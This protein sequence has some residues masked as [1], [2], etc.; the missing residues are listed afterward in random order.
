MVKMTILRIMK[1]ATTQRKT[2]YC[3][4]IE[5]A[6][7]TLGHATNGQL[8]TK[9]RKSYPELSATT[10]HRASSRLAS[11]G[12]ISV[13]PPCKDGSMRY[14][15]NIKA[16]DHF[17]CLSCDLLRDTNIKGKVVPILESSIGNCSISGQ[18]T[19]SGVCDK[20]SKK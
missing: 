9:L 11:R 4:D 1:S 3:T 19:I 12:A 6:L 7:R 14:D 15:A 2:K 16:H 8:L 17:Q 20:C 5:C 10:V 13:A 18:L